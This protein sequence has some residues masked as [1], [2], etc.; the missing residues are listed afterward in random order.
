MSE[1][2][3]LSLSFRWLQWCAVGV[4]GGAALGMLEAALVEDDM[5]REVLGVRALDYAL[6]LLIGLTL[7]SQVFGAVLL[8]AGAFFLF[9]SPWPR[10]DH[11]GDNS[12]L[13]LAVAVTLTAI[14]TMYAAFALNKLLPG[15]RSPQTIAG[16]LG[17]ALAALLA[18][19]PVFWLLRRV[20]PAR[21]GATH[22]PGLLIA[23][24]AVEALALM[25]FAWLGVAQTPTASASTA[26]ATSEG[27]NVLLITVDTLRA[28]HLSA[29][30]YTKIQTPVI[31]S[32]AAEGALFAR[33][34]APASWTLPSLA[35]LHTG[36]SPAV[37]RQ[38]SDDSF[39]DPGIPT[40]AETY[41][42]NGFM[43]AAIVNN[44]YID[45][46]KG[47]DRGFDV[48]WH[49]EDAATA[50]TFLGLSLY[51]FLFP[52]HGVPHTAERMTD[53][54]VDF[55]RRHG[56][57]RFFLWVHY[58]DPH[59]PYGDWYIDRYPAYDRDY[60]GDTPRVIS[61]ELIDV[62]EASRETPPP[63][64]IRHWLASYDAEIMYLDTQLRRLLNTL[65]ELD[66][67]KNTLV[68][69][70]ADHGEE[71]WE[72]AYL[73]HS[74]TLYYE[75]LHVPLIMRYPPRIAPG[76][77]IETTVSLLDVAPTLLAA[78]NVPVH[79]GLQGRSLWPALTGEP[80]AAQPVHSH[81]ERHQIVL[82]GIHT[83]EYD[84]IRNLR[85]GR[86]MLFNVP[87]DPA[88]Q[89][90]AV[91]AQGETAAEL[92]GQLGE[93]LIHSARVRKRLPLTGKNRVGLKKRV[94]KRMKNLGYIE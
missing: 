75:V 26:T 40:L 72:H 93:W 91:A 49:S 25:A 61:N 35:S 54:A 89:H 74:W 67:E 27:A 33:A 13:R 55:L 16:N 77:R 32:L 73:G 36:N 92:D 12:G 14:G 43:T 11:R 47:L 8:L 48:Y 71:F 57:R 84:L 29:Y 66:L 24:G 81:Q 39:L 94:L 50:P 53:T 64:E 4:L 79:K 88:Q 82:R 69:L 28:D 85:T 17:L 10:I 21:Q 52:L 9:L 38:F 51:K 87:D 45:P 90:D 23:A 78:S 30:G 86:L 58:L 5:L 80:F 7:Y 42:E 59:A 15:F 60:R 68:V 20:L 22:T 18:V 31:D 6:H 44:P 34:I 65:A 1:N 41:R 37:H 19:F 76:R 46:E 63:E 2:R 56:D 3:S 62:Y 70:T 83:D